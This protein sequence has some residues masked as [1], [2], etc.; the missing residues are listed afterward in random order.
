MPKSKR[1]SCKIECGSSNSSSSSSSNSSS[2]SSSNSSSSSSSS[3]I[4]KKGRASQEDDD[5]AKD[6]TWIVAAGAGQQAQEQN[7]SQMPT[8]LHSG[9]YDTTSQYWLMEEESTTHLCELSDKILEGIFFTGY[10][11]PVFV[12]RKLTLVNKHIYNLSK[13]CIRYVDASMMKIREELIPCIVKVSRNI[14][15]LSLRGNE[16]LMPMINNSSEEG[17]I[18]AESEQFE[19]A[20]IKI[21]AK[22]LKY[23]DLKGS[24]VGDASLL[25]VAKLKNLEVLDISKICRDFKFT[26]TDAGIGIL[27][28]TLHKLTWLNLAMSPITDDATAIIA[29][30]SRKAFPHLKHLGL[31]LC[32]ELTDISLLNLRTKPLE[33]LDL[34]G[35]KKITT[36]GFQ[37]L[38]QEQS[39]LRNSLVR[40]AASFLPLVSDEVVQILTEC[41]PNLKR[42]EFR[43][44]PIRP[45]IMETARVALD[46]SIF[47]HQ[48]QL[49]LKDKDNDIMTHVK[50]PI[51]ELCV[52]YKWPYESKFQD[53]EEEAME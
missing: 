24:S 8:P 37:Y 53:E 40:L 28:E 36:R 26:I 15:I 20:G 5:F 16:N 34:H 27:A 38:T 18:R 29:C 1:S 30:S 7:S 4:S 42:L 46:V 6:L 45:I 25:S 23:L 21:L 35:V 33:T 2:S 19:L 41:L 11:D 22:T 32:T 13:R 49:K 39:P 17:G 12:I 9:G 14:S 52:S 48:D 43:G 51:K 44:V 3:R 31:Q 50:A 10:F 47:N